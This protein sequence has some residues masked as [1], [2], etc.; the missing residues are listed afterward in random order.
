MELGE[1]SCPVNSFGGLLRKGH[2][3]GATGLA[4][5]LELTERIQCRSGRRQGE[6]ARFGLAHNGRGNIGINATATVVAIL[7]QA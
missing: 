7:G 1:E 6:G 2:P 4:Q 3:V 5:V